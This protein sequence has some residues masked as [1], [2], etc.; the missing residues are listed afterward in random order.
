MDR[1]RRLGALTYPMLNL[2]LVEGQR[3]TAW[4]VS[5]E[6]F[7]NIA[8]LG[9]ALLLQNNNAKC[10]IIGPADSLESNHQHESD[11]SRTREIL[12]DS[13]KM[14]ADTIYEGPITMTR[15]G[16][17]FFTVEGPYSAKATKG[18]QEDLLIPAEW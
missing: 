14:S 2:L 8:R 18:K 1:A 11:Y 9:S 15:K 12:L 3:L 5:A 10:R 6:E 7:N 16:I 13:K 4:I 17:G